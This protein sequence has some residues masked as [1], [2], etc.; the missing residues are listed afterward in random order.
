[1]KVKLVRNM[2][3]KILIRFAPF[4]IQFGSKALTANHRVPRGKMNS[5]ASNSRFQKSSGVFSKT[6]GICDTQLRWLG[7]HEI[8][9]K[10]VL[11]VI[12]P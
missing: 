7:P 5:S 1:M 3:S 11:V 4:V 6:R 12:E 8:S 10:E 9:N 2:A